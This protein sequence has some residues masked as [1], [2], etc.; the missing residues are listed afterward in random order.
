MSHV[1]ANFSKYDFVKVRVH[2]AD[3]GH[4]YVLSRFLVSR[5][6]TS[7]TVTTIPTQDIHDRNS[8]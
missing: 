3:S 4:Y 7:T 6:L 1:K 5:V 8:S 2:L